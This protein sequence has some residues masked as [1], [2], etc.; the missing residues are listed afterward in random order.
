MRVIGVFGYIGSG[1]DTVAQILEQQ[2]GYTNYSYGDLV[3][4]ESVARGRTK[5]RADLQATRRECDATFGK[6]YFPDKIVEHIVADNAER[7][8]ISGIRNPEDALIPKKFF[9]QDMLLIFVDVSK[10]RRYERL[11]K[12]GSERDAQTYGAFVR[13]EKR[14]LGIFD[15]VATEK[16]CDV[17]ISNNQG[18]RT[19]E[20]RIDTLMRNIKSMQYKREQKKQRTG[21]HGAGKQ[22]KGRHGKKGQR[23]R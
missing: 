16:L 2:Y 19:L 13:Q 21:K 18:V 12:R 14:E 3:R 15:F 17:A 22:R 10:K 4:A 23:T 11:K 1:K 6:E 8:I 9:G 7:A 20:K 5:D